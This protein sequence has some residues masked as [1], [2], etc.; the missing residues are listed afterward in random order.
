[1]VNIPRL[2]FKIA[3]KCTMG[4]KTKYEENCFHEIMNNQLWKKVGNKV[5]A[6]P[7]LSLFPLVNLP[8]LKVFTVNKKASLAFF[9]R[10]LMH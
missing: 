7:F 3:A 10:S 1:M 5:S 8:C 9:S 2:K 4:E 6:T